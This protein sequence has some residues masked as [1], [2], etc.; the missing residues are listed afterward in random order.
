M[1]ITSTTDNY[2]PELPRFLLRK[3][4]FSPFLTRETEIEHARTVRGPDK[5]LNGRDS[6]RLR[7][8]QGTTT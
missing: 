8:T 6:P 2:E 1:A 3:K 7:V 5:F 4:R